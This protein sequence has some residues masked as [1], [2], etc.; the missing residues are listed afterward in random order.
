MLTARCLCEG[1]RFEITGKLG[2]VVYCHCSQCRRASGSAF[3]A[4]ADLHT[5]D[6]RWISGRELVQEYES[7]PGQFRAF[8]ARCGSPLYSR[9]D[10]DPAV[11]RVRLG[12]LDGDPG[13]RSQAHYWVGSKAPWFEISDA[14][15]RFEEAPPRSARI[16]HITT[17]AALRAQCAGD[18]YSPPSLAREGFVHCTATRSTLLAVARD[19]YDGATSPL[20]VL[21]I[22]PLRLAAELRFE[23]PAPIPGGGAAHLASGEL[24]PHLYGPLELA[25]IVGVG[26]LRRA[27]R[28]FAWPDTFDALEKWFA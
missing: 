20:L 10:A 19:Y 15:P 25:A 27:G 28:E 21:E 12:S 9:V 18:S 7:S 13:R 22:D 8:C 23:A 6:V 1:V 4:N 16:Y 3:A 24:F 11:I 14:L 2:P 26:E 17:V 5:R